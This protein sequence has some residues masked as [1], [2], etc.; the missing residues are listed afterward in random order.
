[1][2]PA[3]SCSS[4]ACPSVEYWAASVR[5][6]WA[7]PCDSPRPPSAASAAAADPAAPSG[8]PAPPWSAPPGVA[9]SPA[10]PLGAGAGG[11]GSAGGRAVAAPTTMPR[12][13]I[14]AAALAATRLMGPVRTAPP[15]SPGRVH[16]GANQVGPQ[17][18][19]A[20]SALS[21]DVAGV[22]AGPSRLRGRTP[23]G[24]RRLPVRRRGLLP[25]GLLPLRLLLPLG[26]LPLALRPERR[27]HRRAGWHGLRRRSPRDHQ[28]H[29]AGEREERGE[30][31]EVPAGA[32]HVAGREGD[33]VGRAVHRD[34]AG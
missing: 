15:S 20:N 33:V 32:D 12:T 2:A 26:L 1:S 5:T 34:V 23:P 6:S 9:A 10:P 30:E 13:A 24:R 7:T 25:P 29:R 18:K 22:G 27:V 17:P 14:R 8:P 11:V 4:S 31:D 16:R 3:E 28:H 21:C 19:P